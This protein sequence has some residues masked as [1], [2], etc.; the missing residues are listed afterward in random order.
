MRA[1]YI[2]RVAA[3]SVAA[4]CCALAVFAGGASAQGMTFPA[5]GLSI[6]FPGLPPGATTG[7]CPSS[8]LNASSV[9]FTFTSGNAVS[10]GPT[11]NPM[12]FGGT[13]QGQAQLVVVDPPSTVPIVIDQG[14]ML[15][16]FGVNTN[17]T[18]NA[19]NYDG[20]NLAFH[21]GSISVQASFGGT[22]SASGNESGWGHL[23]VTCS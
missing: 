14:H 9:A 4:G 1:K 10:Y 15:A 22:T 3:A 23:K 11:P 20:T 2:V 7:N 8:L 21:G 13:A 17:P 5:A 16:W 18:G 6:G 19:Q 12:T